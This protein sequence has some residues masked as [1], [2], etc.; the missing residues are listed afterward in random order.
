VGIPNEV[1]YGRIDTTPEGAGYDAAVLDRLDDHFIRLIEQERLLGASYLLSRQGKIFAHRAIGRLASD[2]G[3]T[4]L[5]TDSIRKVYSITKMFT[6]VAVMMMVEDG[7]LDLQEPVSQFLP[8]FNHPSLEKI[9]V[10]HLLTHTS[11]LYGDPGY[12]GEAYGMPW[13]EDVP[14]PD[15]W[16]WIQK[17]LVGPYRKEPGTEWVYSTACF[18]LL[19]EIVTRVSGVPFESFIRRFII[20]PL[21]L[22][23]TGFSVAEELWEEV[24][25]VGN[26]DRRGLATEEDRPGKAPR[27]GN[28]LYSTLEDLW[29]FGQMLLNNGSFN[30][31][32]ILGRKTV[33]AMTRNQLRDVY[34]HHWGNKVH[35]KPFGLGF[36]LKTDSFMTPG[37]YCHE[38]YGRSALYI[39]PVEQFIAVF[40]VPA[41]EQFVEESLVHSRA[42][43]WSG[44]LP[45]TERAVL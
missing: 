13:F 27:A 31:T 1:K 38:G 10:F 21:G 4:P 3:D 5:T 11:G 35:N 16:S 37:T 17:V 15:D 14:A 24:C 36:N 34:A 39:D 6:A 44:L 9:K 43:M 45:M 33:E 7:K 8:E 30:G 18:S 25:V 40:F 19:G 12:F 29:S 20:E 2:R 41:M 22:K 28:G 32:T 42:I 23:R 26:W